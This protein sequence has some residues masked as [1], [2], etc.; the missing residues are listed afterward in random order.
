MSIEVLDSSTLNYETQ[1]MTKQLFMSPFLP[2]TASLEDD[3]DYI[4]DISYQIYLY[5]DHHVLPQVVFIII[6]S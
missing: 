3:E 4:K 5:F 6:N 1:A 2:L